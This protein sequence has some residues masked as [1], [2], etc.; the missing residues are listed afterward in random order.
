MSDCRRW[1]VPGGTFFFTAVTYGRR[2]IL[3]DATARK[4]LREAIETV[5]QQRPIELVAIVL[6][7]DHVHTIW[8][9]PPDD[10]AYP[11]RWKRIKEEFTLAYLAHGGS[12][13]QLTRSR[14]RQGERGVWQRRYWE[15]AVRDEDDLDR[16]VDY[17]HWNPKKHGLVE[18]IRD[19]PWSSFS[20]YVSL[21]QYTLDW[22]ATDPTPGYN[23]PEWGE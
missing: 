16:C 7:P 20:R 18:N 10:V 6:L 9:L 21:G 12:E 22:G 14:I 5:R 4:F 1:Y 17:I 3:C 13:G 2:P 19:W 15:H 11:L 23:A 8:T